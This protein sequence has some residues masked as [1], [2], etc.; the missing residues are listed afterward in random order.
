[1]VKNR[2][3]VRIVAEGRSLH[4]RLFTS[5]RS[6]MDFSLGATIVLSDLRLT[7]CV[8]AIKDRKSGRMV[9]FWNVEGA[10]RERFSQRMVKKM[11]RKAETYE[12]D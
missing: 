10:G 12:A 6:A 9:D 3:L 4:E 5:F 2:Y 1:M 11:M 7:Y 8:V